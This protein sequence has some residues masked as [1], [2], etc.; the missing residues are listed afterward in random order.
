[1][2]KYLNL[3]RKFPLES[4]ATIQDKA[5]DAVFAF[6]EF[7]ACATKATHD[8]IEGILAKKLLGAKDKTKQRAIDICL[9]L[10][11]MDKNGNQ[12]IE[13]LLPAASDKVAKTAAATISIFTRAL[14]EFGPKIIPIKVLI[15]NVGTFYANS[16]ATVRDQV[17]VY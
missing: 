7:A 6:V 13:E 8:I 1:M 2:N 16:D 14:H 10:I 5:L 3:V 17:S 15:K 12:V 11:E 4:T 9:M